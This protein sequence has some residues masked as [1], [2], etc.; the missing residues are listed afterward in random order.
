MFKNFISV[1]NRFKI[2]GALNLIGLIAGFCLQNA[3]LRMGIRSR[4]PDGVIH[5][6]GCCEF[7][8]LACGDK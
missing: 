7:P 4:L 5:Y 3:D 8:E 6:A 1:L 2:A